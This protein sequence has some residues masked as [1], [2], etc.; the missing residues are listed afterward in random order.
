MKKE[1]TN[2]AKI[3]HKAMKV[4]TFSSCSLCSAHFTL[5]SQTLNWIERNRA[6][7]ADKCNAGISTH[8]LFCLVLMEGVW[9]S[10][11]A[12][13]HK[14]WSCVKRQWQGSSPAAIWAPKH[15]WWVRSSSA[16]RVRVLSQEQGGTGRRQICHTFVKD[17]YKQKTL[18]ILA[19]QERKIL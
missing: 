7:Q 15:N 10:E 11:V 4:K 6:C 16:C 18:G 2:P 17:T 3:L 19:L 5:V 8:G 9:D 14:G 13:Y 1:K 12:H